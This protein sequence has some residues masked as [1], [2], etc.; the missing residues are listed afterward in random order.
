MRPT[1]PDPLEPVCRLLDELARRLPHGER[2][3]AV[4]RTVAA[5]LVALRERRQVEDAVRQLVTTLHQLDEET[6]GGCRREFQ[7]N[8]PAVGRF[9]EL[10][11]EELLP[12]LRNAG[13][14]V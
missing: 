13:H 3:D 7:R 1:E 11:Q 4:R 12:I 9:L 10:L 6:V 14:Q 8:A 2:E 5:T